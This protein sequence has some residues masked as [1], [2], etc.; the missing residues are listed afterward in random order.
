MVEDFVTST[1]PVLDASHR[2]DNA[3]PATEFLTTLGGDGEAGPA[4]K[5]ALV[6]AAKEGRGTAEERHACRCRSAKAFIVP[7]VNAMNSDSIADRLQ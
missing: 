5:V 7:G 4:E 2:F 1:V 3:F 6:R